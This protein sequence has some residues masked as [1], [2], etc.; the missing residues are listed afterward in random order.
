MKQFRFVIFAIA[1]LVSIAV[2]QDKKSDPPAHV[3]FTI[4]ETNRMRIRQLRAEKYQAQVEKLQTMLR[5]EA[6]AIQ[7][8][9]REIAAGH[10]IPLDKLAEYEVVN[11]ESESDRPILLKKKTAPK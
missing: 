8:E 2:A 9:F 10:G 1:I 4:E 3:T 5:A 11:S 7:N 6:E